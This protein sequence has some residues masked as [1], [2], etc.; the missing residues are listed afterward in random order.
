MG[1]GK[2]VQTLAYLSS[3]KQALP[4]LVI[5]PLSYSYEIGKEKLKNLSRKKVKM[6]E[7]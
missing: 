6:E 1:L 3:E 7:F 4:A 2:T 5:A